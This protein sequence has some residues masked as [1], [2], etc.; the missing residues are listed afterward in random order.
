MDVEEAGKAKQKTKEGRSSIPLVFSQ[1]TKYATT[2]MRGG[3]QS[4]GTTTADI[5]QGTTN[6][7]HQN[8]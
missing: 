6:A 5:C 2:D 7:F 3:T 8:K 4:T 1:L